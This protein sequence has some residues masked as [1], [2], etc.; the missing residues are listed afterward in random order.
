[1]SRHQHSNLRIMCMQA[2]TLSPKIHGITRAP[3]L[4]VTKPLSDRFNHSLRYYWLAHLALA[5]KLT[6]S[7]KLNLALVLTGPDLYVPQ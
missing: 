1:M 7:Q 2:S 5:R 3:A 4:Q 6:L